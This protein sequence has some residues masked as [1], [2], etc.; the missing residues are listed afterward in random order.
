MGIFTGVRSDV[1]F[2]GEAAFLGEAV[3][4]VDVK[5]QTL[6]DEV[7]NV[8][9]E[10]G[11][12]W[13]SLSIDVVDEGSPIERPRHGG[14]VSDGVMVAV[15]TEDELVVV[16]EAR[17]IAMMRRVSVAKSYHSIWDVES[18]ITWRA[19]SKSGN[20]RSQQTRPR[21]PVTVPCTYLMKLLQD[22]SCER[23]QKQ[24]KLTRQYFVRSDLRAT[25]N[26]PSDDV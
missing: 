20:L 21:L 8:Q 18:G 1:V 9:S 15:G 23:G 22:R 26:R 5:E 11:W 6:E 10:L 12:E 25:V 2:R 14:R 16:N 24:L 13:E 7:V 17:V 19:A 3:R 4:D